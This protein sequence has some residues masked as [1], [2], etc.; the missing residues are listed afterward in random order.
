MF[1]ICLLSLLVSVVSI[2]SAEESAF[3]MSDSKMYFYGF[4]AYYSFIQLK[5]QIG[6]RAEIQGTKFYSDSVKVAVDY[7]GVTVKVRTI[8]KIEG[9]KYPTTV[10]FFSLT[11]LLR[12]WSQLQKDASFSEQIFSKEDI[13]DL[14]ANGKNWRLE[15]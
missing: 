5:G 11:G 7:E 14:L 4:K 3:S 12:N 13:N 2:V 1:R 10:I 6:I 15:S 8:A 9:D